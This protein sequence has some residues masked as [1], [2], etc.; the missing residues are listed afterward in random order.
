[1][2]MLAGLWSKYKQIDPVISLGSNAWSLV[3]LLAGGSA[4]SSWLLTNWAWFWSQLGWAAIPVGFVG[5]FF[6]LS[7]CIFLAGF[8]R[9]LWSGSPPTVA[10]YRSKSEADAF[11]AHTLTQSPPSLESSI[12]VSDMRMTMDTIASDRTS[13]L[14]MWVFN[15][16]GR[17]IEF[18][19]ATGQISYRVKNGDHFTSEGTLPTPSVHPNSAQTALQNQECIFILKQPVPQDDAAAL[20]VKNATTIHFDLTKLHT[21]VYTK[22]NPEKKERLMLWDG[23]TAGRGYSFGRIKNLTGLSLTVGSVTTAG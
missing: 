4:A 23:I 11:Y 10:A 16:S 18:G 2:K 20:K 9:F 14:S 3:G 5:S 1:M 21:E 8:G 17:V 15:G 7:V 12:H 13:E 19:R 22:A 6:A